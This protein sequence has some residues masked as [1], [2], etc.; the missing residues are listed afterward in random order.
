MNDSLIGVAE[1]IS[2]NASPI[3]SSLPIGLIASIGFVTSL[4]LAGL[5]LSLGVT[6][7][8]YCWKLGTAKGSLICFFTTGTLKGSYILGCSLV[9][10]YTGAILKMSSK[11]LNLLSKGAGAAG[12]EMP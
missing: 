6:V 10:I 5:T 12:K 9:M 11:G 1:R 2:S 4:I 8:G 3:R 7:V